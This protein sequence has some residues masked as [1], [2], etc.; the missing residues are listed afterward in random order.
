TIVFGG[1][2]LLNSVHV[3]HG[4][5]PGG[6]QTPGALGYGETLGVVRGNKRGWGM[7]AVDI[8]LGA[9]GEVADRLVL[10]HRIRGD[11][12]DVAVTLAVKVLD[13]RRHDKSL[14]HS[15]GQVQRELVQGRVPAD[16]QASD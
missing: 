10:D 9:M 6:E 14:A 4:G 8:A 5:V 1:K 16:V 3:Q 15:G 13:E 7:E 2:E 11:D 12:H